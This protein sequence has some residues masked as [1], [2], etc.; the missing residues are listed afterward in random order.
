VVELGNSISPH[1]NRVIHDLARAVEGEGIPGVFD[2][3]P[4]Y[5]SL[6][7]YYD[8][9]VINVS[10][11]RLKLHSL[12]SSLSEGATGKARVVRVPTLYGGEMGPDLEFVARNSNLT[13]QEVIE[14]HSGTDYLVYMLGFSPGYPYLGGMS[15]R[16]ATPRLKTPRTAVPAGSVALAERQTGV[17]PTETP[18][19]WQIL[20]RTPLKFFDPTRQ[21]PSLVEP[22]DYIRFVSIDADEYARIKQQVQEGTYQVQIEAKE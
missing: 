8:P 12:Y 3:T 10:K 20:G 18:G 17:Y 21:P 15:E 2:L 22:G 7:V 5:R 4:S 19:G 16:I 6:L 1:I 9:L 13:P 14:I 11:L